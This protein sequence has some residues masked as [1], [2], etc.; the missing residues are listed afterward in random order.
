MKTLLVGLFTLTLAAGVGCTSTTTEE[1][2]A[3]A[4]AAPATTEPATRVAPAQE[5]E[6]AVTVAKKPIPGEADSTFSL[7][8]PFETVTLKQGAKE[9]VRIGIN[10][11]ANFGEEVALDV[12]GLPAGVTVE[13]DAPVIKHGSMGETLMLAAAPDAALGDFTVKVTGQTASSG[14]DFSKEFEVTVVQ[15]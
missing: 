1:P 15:R 10:R 3:A 8:V 4:P 2:Q 9:E 11:G 6:P 5:A 13:T 12:S 14:A 7:S